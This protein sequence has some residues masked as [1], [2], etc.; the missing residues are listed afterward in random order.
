MS[1][2]RVGL[3]GLIAVL[4]LNFQ[5]Q[6]QVATSNTLKKTENES[7]RRLNATWSIDLGSGYSNEG[8]DEGMMAYL[9]A[10]ANFEYKFLKNLKA[11][12]EPRLRLYEGRDQARYDDDLMSNRF[13]V[14]NMYFG[15]EPIK[16]L[17]LRAGAHSQR[18]M[19][20]PMLISNLRSFAGV[21]EIAKYETENY[22]LHFIAQQLVPTSHS[23]NLEREEKEKVPSFR[24]E[25]LKFD[26]QWNDTLKWESM[27]GLYHWAN[28]P[29]KVAFESRMV[30][31][32][33][34]GGDYSTDAK[35]RFAHEGW[36]AA[37]TL[38]WCTTAPLSFEVE[39]Q[40]VQ[41]QRAPSYA[42][43]AQLVGFGPNYS[44][45]DKEVSFRYRSYF[46]ESDATVAIYSRS[47]FGN[48]NR[49]GSNIEAALKFKDLGFSI[50]G[51]MFAANTIN[52]SANQRYLQ[53]YYFGVE[54][55]YV[56][57]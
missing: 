50:Y 51:E 47:R 43:D 52:S 22:K 20:L 33:S 41:N 5:V 6:A 7:S 17:E 49:Q 31:N 24:T 42:G 9:Y 48:T 53:E 16:Y 4:V 40:R 54:T 29:S 55:D 18:E 27:A 56:S 11:R 8:K 13:N 35:L 15:Y 10:G 28:I 57:F 45:G 2:S 38:C 23:S 36:F 46:I 19:R 1:E 44:F 26:G 14:M 25:A 30:G 37:G 34:G 39:Y 21:K 3:F 12:V 32:M